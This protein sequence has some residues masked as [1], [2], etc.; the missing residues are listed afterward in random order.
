[1]TAWNV[2]PGTEVLESA[3]SNGTGWTQTIVISN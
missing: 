1:M 3:Q 2:Q